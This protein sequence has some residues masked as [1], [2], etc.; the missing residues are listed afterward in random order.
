MIVCP[1]VCV[2]VWG[3]TGQGQLPSNQQRLQEVIGPSLV[4][5][6]IVIF[7]LYTWMLYELKKTRYNALISEF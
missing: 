6:W 4:K 7:T 1:F 2:C 3:G 5:Q